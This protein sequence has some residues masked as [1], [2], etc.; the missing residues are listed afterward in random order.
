MYL[1]ENIRIRISGLIRVLT[2]LPIGRTRP[3]ANTVKRIWSLWDHMTYKRS[4]DNTNRH[5]CGQMI[6]KLALNNRMH[7]HS[8]TGHNSARAWNRGCLIS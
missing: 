2:T 4:A 7:R 8:S 1:A 3:T 6:L 5:L